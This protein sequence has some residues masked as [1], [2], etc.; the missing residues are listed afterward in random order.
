MVCA[1]C[2]KFSTSVVVEFLNHEK[3]C[4]GSTWSRVVKARAKKRRRRPGPKAKGKR[5]ARGK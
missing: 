5:K 4:Q 1:K 2:K 3:T